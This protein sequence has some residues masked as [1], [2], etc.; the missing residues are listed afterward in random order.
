MVF[1]SDL[2][3]ARQFDPS[4]PTWQKRFREFEEMI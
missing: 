2:E 3:R 1:N 4:F